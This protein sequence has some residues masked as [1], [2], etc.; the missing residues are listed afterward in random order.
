[1]FVLEAVSGQESRLPSWLCRL[2][3]PAACPAIRKRTVWSLFSQEHVFEGVN[4]CGR[5]LATT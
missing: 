5:L 4:S 3:Y 1:M 2:V